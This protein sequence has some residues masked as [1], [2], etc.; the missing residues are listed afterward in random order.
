MR[1]KTVKLLFIQIL[2][3]EIVSLDF[4]LP[5]IYPIYFPTLPL[6][7]YFFI[8]ILIKLPFVFY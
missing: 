7:S 6:K 3:V 1:K 4:H 8:K 5:S 2:D